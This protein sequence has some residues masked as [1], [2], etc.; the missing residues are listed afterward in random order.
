MNDTTMKQYKTQGLFSAFLQQSLSSIKII[1]A[2]GSESF[3][4]QK[5]KKHAEEF[6]NAFIMANKVSMSFN[7]SAVLITGLASAM[8]VISGALRGLNGSLSIGDLFIFLGC[9]AA[10]YGPVNSLATAIGAAVAIGA[11][12]KKSL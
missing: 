10:L 12:G 2:F 11:R 5:L 8:L 9:I 6:S 7:Q 3:M 1:Q 4:H